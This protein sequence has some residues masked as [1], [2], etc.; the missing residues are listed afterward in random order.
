MPDHDALELAAAEA[1]EDLTASHPDIASEIESLS[2]TGLDR[3]D[4]EAEAVELF[5]TL[6]GSDDLIAE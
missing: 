5:A 4:I 3:D 2:G 1:L 6:P